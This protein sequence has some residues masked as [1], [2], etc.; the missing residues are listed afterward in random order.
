M[1]FSTHYMY[2]HNIDSITK[3]MATGNTIQAHLAAGQTLLTPSDNPAGASQAVALQNTLAS[4]SQ[5]DTARSYAEDTL[6]QE[7]NTLSSIQSILTGSLS[8]KI[9][10]GGNGAYSDQDRQSL[11]TELK[12]IRGSLRE[13]GNSCDSNGRYIFAGYKTGNAPFADDGSYV[14]GDTPLTQQVSDNV[15]MQVGHTGQQLFMSGT[16]DDLLSA[17]DKAIDALNKPITSEDERQALKDTLDSVN[18]SVK[19][20]I[21]HIGKI[22]SEV[23]C[24]LQQLDSLSFSSD[25]QKINVT[26]RLQQAIGSDSDTQISQS[27]IAAFAL[28]SS[29][30]V[31][32][33][34]QQISIFNFK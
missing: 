12:G 21:D 17:I 7:D 10:A 4:M 23:G 14:G 26:A 30:T 2:Q 1:R 25:A 3:S 31:F 32:Q 13:L 22:Q 28:T 15:E 34:M 5:Y 9:I 29:M 24:N 19:K 6:G 33:A 20:N 8:E 18:N 27:K 11:A 16:S